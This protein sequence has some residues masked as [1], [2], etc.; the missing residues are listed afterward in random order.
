MCRSERI[1]IIQAVG[2]SGCDNGVR[3]D[4][5][6][7][8]DLVCIAVRCAILVRL[9]AI[10]RSETWRSSGVHMQIARTTAIIHVLMLLGQNDDIRIDELILIARVDVA[11]GRGT[12]ASFGFHIKTI[13]ALGLS[14]THKSGLGR[15]AIGRL[16][17]I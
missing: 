4:T 11:Q 10:G 1:Q 13:I 16:G 7:A 9:C 17:G 5:L 14:A 8:Y 12:M 6:P 3:Y 15:I 2:R